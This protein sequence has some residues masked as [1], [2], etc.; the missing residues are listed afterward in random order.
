MTKFPLVSGDFAMP[1]SPQG[2]VAIDSGGTIFGLTG[3]GGA[4]GAGYIYEL[5]KGNATPTTLASF[6]SSDTSHLSR[7]PSGLVADAKGDLFGF[8]Q[9]DAPAVFELPRGGA[10]VE[11][12]ASL[13]PAGNVFG[14]GNALIDS[15]G[16]LFG[17]SQ[18][19]GANDTGTIWELPAGAG[20]ITLLASFPAD[21]GGNP[22][23]NE[24]LAIDAG[25]NLYGAT[26]GNGVD[27]FGGIFELPAGTQ[28]IQTLATFPGGAAGQYSRSGLS[29]DSAGNLFGT[30]AGDL[31]SVSLASGATVFELPQGAS[32]IQTLATFGANGNAAGNLPAGPVTL[33]GAGDLFGVATS[34]GT[35]TPASGVVWELPAGA[36]TITGLHSFNDHDGYGPDAGVTLDASGDIFG[37]TELGGA[38]VGGGGGVLYELSPVVTPPPST[39]VLSAIVSGALPANALIAGQNANIIQKVTVTN[40]GAAPLRGEVKIQLFLSTG[41]TVDSSSI[42]LSPGVQKNVNLK[43]GKAIGVRL[44]AKMISAGA[45]SGSYHLVAE[46]TDPIEN[47]IDAA[48]TSTI[49][50]APAQVDIA[51]SFLKASAK[52]KA[53]K[54]LTLTFTLT[55][56]GNAEAIGLIPI[57]IDLSTDGA[58]DQNIDLA[59]VAHAIHAKPG[60][61]MKI[62]VHDSVGAGASG[63]Y[64][65]FVKLD[66]SDTLGDVNPMN[67][68]FATA[69]A[70]VTIV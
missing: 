43:P 39:S 30:T 11:T 40:T 66:P 60:K 20:A 8:F 38:D 18:T 4:N 50:I 41:S 70:V 58:D 68:D 44:G 12:I 31:G 52:V 14:P 25:G 19:G 45:A 69:T 48:S 47:M 62:T 9:G 13:L 26:E 24:N 53:G 22:N 61:S 35:G 63:A 29:I 36:D 21:S 54:D 42:P 65:V 28:T 32:T 2:E 46:V 6:P 10:A 57:Q 33:D 34:G 27:S 5:A 17:T 49:V 51:G 64:F 15:S 1:T 55:N 16:N 3:A 67:D 23:P 7:N 37:V 59:P 56:D